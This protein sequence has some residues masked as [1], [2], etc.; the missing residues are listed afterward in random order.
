MNKTKRSTKQWITRYIFVIAVFGILAM[1]VVSGTRARY[2]T[3]ATGNDTATVAKWAFSLNGQASTNHEEILDLLKDSKYTNVGH[4]QGQDYAKAL[5]PGM[6]GQLEYLLVNESDVSAEIDEFSISIKMYFNNIDAEKT[7]WRVD[8]WRKWLDDMPIKWSIT[9]LD[10]HSDNGII[11]NERV[12][13]LDGTLQNLVY[14]PLASTPYLESTWTII[15]SSDQPEPFDM[16]A[17]FK[18]LRIN[19]DWP[20]QASFSVSGATLSWSQYE[21]YLSSTY[22]STSGVP[23]FNFGGMNVLY[24]ELTDFQKTSLSTNEEYLNYV[25]YLNA[26][27]IDESYSAVKMKVSVILNFTV[28]QVD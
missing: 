25:K 21:Q 15:S 24:T 27:A 26:D 28:S 4:Q 23:T 18:V 20:Y 22:S 10:R 12:I 11:E 5:V 1:L 2:T 6:N 9:I 8:D 13:D 17:N 3:T 16:N 7:S 19:W 14:N